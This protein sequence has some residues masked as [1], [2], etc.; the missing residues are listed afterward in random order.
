MSSLHR[1]PVATRTLLFLILV[2]AALYFVLPVYW[3]I[4]S[5]TKN[6]P[7]LFGTFGFW[8]AERNFLIHNLERLFARDGGVYI[9]WIFNTIL[10]AGSAALIGSVTCALAGYAFAKFEFPG[11]KIVFNTIFAGLFIPLTALALPIFLLMRDLG[12]INTYQSVI[13]PIAAN[14]FGVY[15]MTAYARGAV[16]IELIESARIEG[17]NELQIFLR[18]IARLI[19]P[20]LATLFLITFVLSWNN[21]FLPL[22]VLNQRSMYPITVGLQNWS[23]LSEAGR[24][25][26]YDV[27]ITGSAVS[28]IPLMVI[29]L[30]LQRYWTK[31]LTVGA[32]K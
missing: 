17:A 9:L 12:W 15:F 13:L 26:L 11:K 24:E 8:I 6:I 20:G 5:S 29:F 16:P 2:I 3:L 28:I 32:V 23:R 21:F 18:V 14:P 10:I 30:F 31:G 19:S 22:I 4:I 7:D 27:V 1:K 25:V